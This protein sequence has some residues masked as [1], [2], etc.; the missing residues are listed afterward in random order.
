VKPT[1]IPLLCPKCHARLSA[2]IQD[3]NYGATRYTATITC[4]ACN[5]VSTVMISGKL[6]GVTI[7]DEPAKI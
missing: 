6:V 5:Q 2:L 3:W 4:P 1:T 7:R